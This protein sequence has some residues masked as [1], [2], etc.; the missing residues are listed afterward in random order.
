[1]SSKGRTYTRPESQNIWLEIKVAG[2]RKIRK[3]AQTTD[4]NEAKKRLQ[5][6]LRRLDSVSFQGAVVDFFSVKER[7]GGLS[8][9]TL[10]NYRTSLRAVDPLLGDLSLIEIDRAELKE[11]VRQ[12]RKTVS[13]TSVRRDL[14]FISTVF[15]H[16][17]ETMADAPP[18]NPVLSFSKKH[19][20]EN[21]RARWLRP[22]EYQRLLK[23]CNNEMQ[24]AMLETFVMTGMR[25]QELVS[26]RQSMINFNRREIVLPKELNKGGRERVIPLCDSLCLTLERLC[27]E[28]PED[29]VFYHFDGRSRKPTPY[30]SFQA[31]W[32]RLKTRAQ[33]EDVRIHDLRHTFASW[34]VQSGGDLLHL[35]DILGHTTLQMVQRYAHLNTAAH[36][37]EI[38]KVF[39]TQFAHSSE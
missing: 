17:I 27:A 12:R 6:E 18:A 19:L 11:L 23:A 14:A 34:F 22:A 1:M 5:L 30:R 26:L 39:G 4:P 29:L 21:Q 24:Q 32:V 2:G 8:P 3:S 38:N 9:K 36:H 15:N 20:K 7:A 16:A 10:S 28:A 37:A 13:D 33:L 25:H 35:R 31:S